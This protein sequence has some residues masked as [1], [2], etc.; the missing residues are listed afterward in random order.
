MAVFREAQRE[1]DARGEGLVGNPGVELLLLIGPDG[2]RVGLAWS[3]TYRLGLDT[4]RS[5]DHSRSAD[6]CR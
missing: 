4:G 5:A 6:E 2:D 1:Q 3:D